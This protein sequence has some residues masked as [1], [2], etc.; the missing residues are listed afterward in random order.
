MFYR[1]RAKHTGAGEWLAHHTARLFQVWALEDSA[2]LGSMT[3]VFPKLPA[4]ALDPPWRSS[5]GSGPCAKASTC[6]HP[7]G[8]CLGLCWFLLWHRAGLDELWS[9]ARGPRCR[10]GKVTV[11]MPQKRKLRSG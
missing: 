10:E 8:L 11:L 6:P 1:W 2:G 9:R 7:P 4:F 3:M 5:Q